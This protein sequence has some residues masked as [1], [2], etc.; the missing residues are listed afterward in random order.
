MARTYS[1][2]CFQNLSAVQYED[3]D[4][5]SFIDVTGN[6]IMWF[7]LVTRTIREKYVASNGLVVDGEVIDVSKNRSRMR[8][9][10]TDAEGVAVEATITY[11]RKADV[12]TTTFSDMTYDGRASMP[13]WAREPMVMM[14]Q[15][16]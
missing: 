15:E 14:R 10:G 3:R 6:G 8:F 5:E 16:E 2:K 13:T 11:D 9:A 1:Q 12:L 7:D 4:D